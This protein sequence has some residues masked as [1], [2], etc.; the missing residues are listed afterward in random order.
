MGDLLR[1]NANLALKNID[2]SEFYEKSVL[3]TGATGLIGRNIVSALEAAHVSDITKPLR[4][5]PKGTWDYIIHAGGYAQPAKFTADPMGTAEVNT[6]VLMELISRLRPHGRLVFL[7]SSEVCIGHTRTLY[8]E[9][10]IGT[11]SPEHPRASYIE[12]KRCG[13]AIC[14]AARAQG[15]QTII[16]RVSL[17]YGPGARRGDKRV[18]SELIDRGI[19]YG[20]IELN[21]GGS[22]RRIYCYVSDVVHMLFNVLLHGDRGIYNVGGKEEVSIIQLAKKIGNIL[23]VPVKTPRNS[24]TSL[25]GSPLHVG[26][27]MSRFENEF[28]PIPYVGLETGLVNTISWHKQL[29]GGL[30][31]A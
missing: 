8:Q 6:T 18:M 28:G 2:T 20:L 30:V 14:H 10:D 17:A 3:V 15:K 9:G 12:A 24:A 5:V 13:E 27:D 29:A 4:G 1:A 22:A 16:A 23:K 21:D 19:K 26:L 11:T 7:S 25:P 31:T